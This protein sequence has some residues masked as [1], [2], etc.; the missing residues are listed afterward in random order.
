MKIKQVS[1][2]KKLRYIMNN[3]HPKDYLSHADILKDYSNDNLFVVV[4]KE[5]QEMVAHFSLE[6][7]GKRMYMK[8]F[9]ILGDN[10][11]NKYMYKSIKSLIKMLPENTYLCLTI[12]PSNDKMKSVLTNLHFIVEGQVK[13]SK[14]KNMYDL[15]IYKKGEK[16]Q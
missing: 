9:S 3:T 2:T 6:E 12:L 10:Y 4:D 11:G 16:N 14:N 5:K 8:R 13:S 7:D 15:Y 1:N